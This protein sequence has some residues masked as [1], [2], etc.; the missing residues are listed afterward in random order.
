MC[1]CVCRSSNIF[2]NMLAMM[3]KYAGTLESLV[4][5]R[6]AQLAQEKRTTEALLHRMLP[7]CVSIICHTDDRFLTS[8]AWPT[9]RRR[10]AWEITP[11]HS[12]DRNGKVIGYP[13]PG[14]H[15]HQKL[16]NSSDAIGRPNY[17]RLRC[18]IHRLISPMHRTDVC[19]DASN[20]QPMNGI[21]QHLGESIIRRDI[22]FNMSGVSFC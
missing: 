14:S 18:F 17:D 11:L 2:D 6:T 1:W 9:H 5:D 19:I 20:F 7:R 8:R 21:K 12:G 3:Q 22:C 13:Y 4:D 10:E 16:S 15:H